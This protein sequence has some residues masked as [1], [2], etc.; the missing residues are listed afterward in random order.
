MKQKQ[1]SSRPITIDK[2]ETHCANVVCTYNDPIEIGR[3]GAGFPTRSLEPGTLTI[4]G[5]DTNNIGLGGNVSFNDDNGKLIV[6]QTHGVKKK[7]VDSVSF[8]IDIEELCFTI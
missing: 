3:T 4:S 6:F 5:I 8:T 1:W 7:D 2:S